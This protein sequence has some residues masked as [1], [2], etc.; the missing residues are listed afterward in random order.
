MPKL[1][2][3]PVKV[4]HLLRNGFLR[5]ISQGAGGGDLHLFIDD[6]SAHIQGGTENKGK[7]E[8]LFTWLG[9]SERP[10]PMM[11]SGRAFWHPG[12]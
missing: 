12:K 7:Q 6:R 9:Q 5:Q 8:T 2:G 3:L 1:S 10:D 4:N 11:Q